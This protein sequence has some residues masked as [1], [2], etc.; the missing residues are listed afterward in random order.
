[1][2]VRITIAFLQKQVPM[3]D[4]VTSLLCLPCHN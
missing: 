2:T 3:F 4:V 1:M